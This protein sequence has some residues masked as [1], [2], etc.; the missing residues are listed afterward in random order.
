[1][2]PVNSLE[3]KMYAL[4]TEKF[5][6]LKAKANSTTDEQAMEASR[7]FEA[8]FVKMMLNE[9][10]NTLEDGLFGSQPG[11]DFYQG[12]FFDEIADQ[13]SK[14]GEIGL[15]KSI[16]EQLRPP[17]NPT[18]DGIRNLESKDRIFVPQQANASI[19][20]DQLP[21]VLS[22]RLKDY[23]P[24]VNQASEK[25]GVEKSMI[26]SI[27]SQESYGNPNAV[28]PVGAKGLMQL[29]DATAKELGVKD[30]FDIEENI[31][32]GTKYFRQ[33]KDRYKDDEKAL[34]AYNAGP[35]NVDKYNGIPPFKETQKYISR[36]KEFINKMQ[37]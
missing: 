3:Q 29:M 15:A 1:M 18:I 22:K 4:E 6:D 30:S 23:E 14:N 31:F 11:A 21:N 17:V 33:M 9:L 26:Y 19:D 28:S 37:Q 27:I 25:Y 20:L 10:N 5:S 13:I 8:I 34:A 35:A 32:A 24:I 36:I 16:Y 2:I 7:G 12:M